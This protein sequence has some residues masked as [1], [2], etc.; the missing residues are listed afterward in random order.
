[1]EFFKQEYWSELPFPPLG[2]LPDPGVESVSPAWEVDS[3]P[4]KINLKDRKERTESFF[5]S[6]LFLSFTF[7]DTMPVCMLYSS[8]KINSTAFMIFSS[9]LL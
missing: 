1:M 8:F 5:S 2:S 9:L 4:I 7:S 6:E 3:I